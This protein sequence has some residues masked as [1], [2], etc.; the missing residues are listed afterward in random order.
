MSSYIAEVHTY[1]ADDWQLVNSSDPY[2]GSKFHM[3]LIRAELSRRAGPSAPV[4]HF[5]VE[6]GGVDSSISAALDDSGIKTY[7]KVFMLY[8]VRL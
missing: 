5:T 1:D 6:P 4:R 7:I 2:G 8:L 3:D